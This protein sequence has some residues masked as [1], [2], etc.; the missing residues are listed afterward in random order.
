MQRAICQLQQ[1]SLCRPSYKQ[2]VR[3]PA[4][5]AISADVVGGVSQDVE[6]VQLF[7][8]QWNVYQK[9]LDHDYLHHSALYGTLK[10]YLEQRMQGPFSMLDLGCGDSAYISRTLAA[11]PSLKPLLQ[12]YTGVDLSSLAMQISQQNMAAAARDT[13]VTHIE[14]DMLHYARTCQQQYDVIL[15]SFAMHHLSWEHKNE[16]LGH[17]SR[18]LKLGGCFCLIDVFLEEGQSRTEYM[19]QFVDTVNNKWTEMDATQQQHSITHVTNHD[20]PVEWSALQACAAEGGL[21]QGVQ[22]LCSSPPSKAVVFEI[23]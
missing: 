9:M 2:C 15:A 11:S 17:L 21:F 10:Q 6:S 4:I 13:S 23:N 14:D 18:M 22:L 8:A 12:S 1:R 19:E 3:M 7:K 16:F 20:F 5:G